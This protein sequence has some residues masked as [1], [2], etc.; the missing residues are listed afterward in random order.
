MTCL[1]AISIGLIAAKAK[2]SISRPAG[3][4]TTFFS[5][6]R[7][8]GPQMPMV[9]NFSETSVMVTSRPRS[10][11]TRRMYWKSRGPA[12]APFT[13]RQRSVM[14]KTVKSARTMPSSSRKWV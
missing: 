5:V 11:A 6:S 9:M 12:S 1:P 8:L 7:A 2:F 10:S 14:R 13:R 3:S 4:T